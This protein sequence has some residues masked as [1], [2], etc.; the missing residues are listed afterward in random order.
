MAPGVHTSIAYHAKA[1]MSQYNHGAVL[2]PFK[3]SM[4]LQWQS[5]AR[6]EDAPDTK[7]LYCS[8]DDGENWTDA[9]VLAPAR[10]DALVTSGG[11]WAHGDTLVA[12]LNVWPIGLEPRGG[13]VEYVSSTDG[14]HWTAPQRLLQENGEPVNGIIEQ[15]IK[16]LPNRRLLTAVHLPP[17]LH[18]QPFF[19]DDPSGCT[20]WQPGKM[21]NLSYKPEMSREIEPSWYLRKDGAIVMVFRDQAGSFKVLAAVSRDNGITWSTP[22]LTN[23]P[24]SRAKQSAGNLPDET[25]YLI[26]NPSGTKKRSPLAVTLSRTGK[27]FDKCFLLRTEAELP[28]L[29]FEGRYKSTGY[30][31]PKS[32]VWH[33]QL[34]VSYAVNKEDITVTRVAVDAL[35]EN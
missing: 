25:A 35:E 15:D 10:K 5:A 21:Q 22:I 27:K 13:Y 30:S 29:Q 2:F 1:G 7:V 8:S 3:G 31:Y 33:E 23:M 19:T 11:W 34:W 9:K 18:V 4:Y 28:P 14:I 24:D 20:G 17:G 32:I 26:N 6:D 12:Y 16:A